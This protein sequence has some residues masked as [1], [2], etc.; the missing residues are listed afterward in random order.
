MF[1]QIL[2]LNYNL[3]LI[4]QSFVKILKT[5]NQIHQKIRTD[6]LQLIMNLLGHLSSKRQKTLSSLTP[7]TRN[8]NTA[9]LDYGASCSYTITANNLTM[10]LKEFV[11]PYWGS[12]IKCTMSDSRIP[13]SI[14]KNADCA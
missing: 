3:L 12:D 14:Y 7:Q 10:N 1:H 8:T 5:R 11:D 4:Y 9:T 2:Q 6:I 13:R